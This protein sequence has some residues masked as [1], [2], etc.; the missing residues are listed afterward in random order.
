MSFTR[1][2]EGAP[3][4]FQTIYLDVL[5]KRKNRRVAVGGRLDAIDGYL[6]SITRRT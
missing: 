3:A 6:T 1:A 4:L 2:M 5:A